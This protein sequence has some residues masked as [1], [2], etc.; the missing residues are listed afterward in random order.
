[1]T[2]SVTAFPT[3]TATMV[4]AAGLASPA[5]MQGLELTIVATPP[6]ALAV[7]AHVKPVA[8]PEEVRMVPTSS[9]VIA[10][11]DGIIIC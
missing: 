1:V 4:T 8:A 9:K 6:W 5:G 3:A 10:R 11:P 2:W 7:T